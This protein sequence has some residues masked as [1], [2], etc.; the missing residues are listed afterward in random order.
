MNVHSPL[1]SREAA[2]R[3]ASRDWKMLIDG[4][5]LDGSTQDWLDVRDPATGE[6]IARAPAG[7]AAD[8]HAAVAA[9]KAAFD[10]RRW[11]NLGAEERSRRLWRVADLI[12]RDAAKIQAVE[13]LNNGAPA[14]LAA[15]F[16]TYAAKFFRH[17]AGWCDK[18]N[19]ETI[20]ISEPGAP[21]HTYT[22]KE[23]LGVAGLIVPW[24]GPFASAAMKVATALTAGCTCVLKP[25]EETPLSALM[26][27]ELL[28]EA[29]IP[30][31]VVNI[32]PGHGHIAGAALANHPDV[33]KISF[34]GSTEVG[35]LIANA[36]TGNLKKVSLE[37]GGKS[38]SIIF[39]DADLSKAIPGAALGTF[40]NTGQVCIAGTRVLVQRSVYD[41]VVEG[42]AAVGR[43]LHLGGGF[44]PEAQIGPL[45]SAKQ[46]ERV[47][48]MID[49]ARDEGAQV[50][51]G[52]LPFE[53]GYFVEPTVITNARPDSVVVR[54]EIFGPVIT[55]IPFDDPEEALSIGNDTEYGLAAAVWTRDIGR[56]QLIANSIAAG[57]V[58]VNCQLVLSPGAPFGGYKQSGWGRENGIEGLHGF[59]QT[60]TVMTAL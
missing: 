21:F 59:M 31:G 46:L 51:G 54:D 27:G 49:V 52:G 16:T 37:L 45:I 50:L 15:F 3:M 57:T 44:D 4:E 60:K 34:T 2:V 12:E 36:A 56:S 11:L 7:G 40:Y 39:D 19:G 17:Y 9:A 8:I 23:P 48:G 47:S 38:P 5:W 43:S 55:A 1:Q 29:G 13:Q 28:I 33:S 18:I 22:R 14:S 25:S 41:Q 24:N 26:L 35:K 58:W 10:D 53:R 30:A 20:E 32:V 6:V 42:M